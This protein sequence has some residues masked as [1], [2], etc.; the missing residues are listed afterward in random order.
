[1]VA[2]YIVRMDDACPTM[3]SERWDRVERI[4]DNHDIHPVVAV[5]PDNREAQ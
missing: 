2:N 3:N 5:I 4:L 1:M